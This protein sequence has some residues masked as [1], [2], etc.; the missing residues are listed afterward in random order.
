MS[1]KPDKLPLLS[2]ATKPR[3]PFVPLCPSSGRSQSPACPARVRRS[4]THAPV[5]FGT[6]THIC[7]VIWTTLRPSPSHPRDPGS[8]CSPLRIRKS[9]PSHPD[10]QDPDLT[11]TQV[12]ARDVGHT[13]VFPQVIPGLRECYLS[14]TKLVFSQVRRSQAHSARSGTRLVCPGFTH[15]QDPSRTQRTTTCANV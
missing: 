5:R 10:D 7:R 2:H 11:N 8:V 12:K 13:S 14:V 9:G 4:R 15:L 6:F 1:T 3:P